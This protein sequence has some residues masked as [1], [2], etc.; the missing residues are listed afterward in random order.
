MA[1]TLF[2]EYNYYDNIS[3]WL[4]GNTDE[5]IYD[6]YNEVSS[7]QTGKT[8]CICIAI[9]HWVAAAMKTNKKLVVYGIRKMVGDVAQLENEMDAAFDNDGWERNIHYQKY[10][11]NGKVYYL[12][13][14]TIRVILMGLNSKIAA[15]R[16]LAIKGIANTRGYDLGIIWREE[17][18]EITN[19]ER[20]AL[21]QACRGFK[22]LIEIGTSN[23]DLPDLDYVEYCSDR[24]AFS[25][26]EL[27]A[28]NRQIKVV[29]EHGAKKLFHYTNWRVNPHLTEANF[30]ALEEIKVLYPQYMDAW[31]YGVPGAIEA[32]IFAHLIPDIQTYMT[33][34]IDRFFAGIDYAEAES[35]QGHWTALSVWGMNNNSRVKLKL[36]EYGHT[37]NPNYKMRFK[38]L[39][40]VVDDVIN[41]IF[42]MS[43]KY[44]LIKQLGID[45][46]CD[47]GGGGNAFIYYAQE[48]AMAL[49]YTWMNFIPIEFKMK[50]SSR[51][52]WTTMEIRRGRLRYD[53]N[54]CPFTK[55]EMNQMVYL[56]TTPRKTELVPKD[57]H[58]DFWDADCYAL[59][60]EMVLDANTDPMM[61]KST[62]FKKPSNNNWGNGGNI[63][64]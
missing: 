58:D 37:N 52:I 6:E 17:A 30:R 18:S 2:A 3:R 9:S 62:M 39:D 20:V 63:L 56:E 48:R 60:P 50:L 57:E 22:K 54:E 8:T 7:R 55:K 38:K 41:Y 16:R 34:P 14:Q 51:L 59:Y 25:K 29:K 19:Y 23:P 32:S 15:G 26:E 11:R 5:A 12:F 49:G 47:K 45:I 46:R 44:P 31:Y 35:I 28:H 13:N 64:A 1:Y 10:K 42:K 33:E 36:G 43:I 53:W 40:E 27:A 21:S 24:Q 4:L 61:S